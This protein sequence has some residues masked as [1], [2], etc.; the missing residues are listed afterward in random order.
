MKVYW[1]RGLEY[2]LKKKYVINF[3]EMAQSSLVYP[4]ISPFLKKSDVI[5]KTK[6]IFDISTEK[7]IRVSYQ[8]SKNC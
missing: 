2:D 7:Y 1:K 3:E 6:C 4:K 8:I 5:K